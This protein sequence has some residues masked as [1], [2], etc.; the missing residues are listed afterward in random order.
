MKVING[1]NAVLGRLATYV[2]KEVLRGEEIAIV[3]C[4]EVII[5]GNVRDIKEKLEERR[6]KG[7]S[8]LRGPKYPRSAERI[9]RRA[10]RGMLPNHRKGRGKEAYKRIKCYDGTPNE[11]K[12]AKKISFGESGKVK[13]SELKRFAR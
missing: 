8:S 4:R 12:E 2:V 1:K 9:V 10:I 11:F 3:N 13:F 7:G 5:T 6:R